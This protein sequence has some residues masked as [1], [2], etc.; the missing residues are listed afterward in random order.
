MPSDSD[1]WDRARGEDRQAF[2]DLFERH[3][4]PIYNYCFRRVGNWASAEDLT[5]VA[6]LEAWRRRD[7][8][9]PEGMVLPWLYGVATER[10]AECE[11]LSPALRAGAR[12]GAGAGTDTR[13]Q[14]GSGCTPRR[15]AADGRDPR[16][17]RSAAERRARRL[18]SLRLVGSQLRGGVGRAER[19]R[20]A[21]CARGCRALELTCG[22]S[23]AT[24]DIWTV[25]PSTW[26]TPDDVRATTR[27]TRTARRPTRGPEAASPEPRSTGS[28]PVAPGRTGGVRAGS[29]SHSSR[30]RSSSL[31]ARP[32]S[33]TNRGAAEASAAEVRASITQGLSVPRNIRGAFTVETR[34]AQPHNQM[35][36]LHEVQAA[37]PT[38]SASSSVPTAASAPV[39]P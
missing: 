37:A 23:E 14:R 4:Q 33:I 39:D 13:L 31:P 35:R 16:P 6:F 15:R 17:L 27:S 11:P 12:Q 24:S 10:V 5:S 19:C 36:G 30:R 2:A 29:A 7:V 22:N 26:R 8:E 38:A 18:R 9:L 28:R 21:P 25:E 32:F 3:S 20:W 1:L 34:P